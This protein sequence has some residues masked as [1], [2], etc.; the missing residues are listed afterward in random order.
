M[1]RGWCQSKVCVHPCCLDGKTQ[2]HYGTLNV[3]RQL[4]F[5][6]T[7]PADECVKHTAWFITP[8]DVWLSGDRDSVPYLL[9]ALHL[10]PYW[11]TAQPVLTCLFTFYRQVM[12]NDKLQLVGMSWWWHEMRSLQFILCGTNLCQ[13]IQYL[14]RHLDQTPD[15]SGGAVPWAPPLL[16]LRIRQPDRKNWVELEAENIVRLCFH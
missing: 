10:N 1:A 4:T 11:S 8:A 3:R 2:D 6:E 16:W 13:L 14:S 15:Q 12:Q 5:I 9:P 7:G